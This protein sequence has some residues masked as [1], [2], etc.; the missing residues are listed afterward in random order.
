M[1]SV[2]TARERRAV[3]L[4]YIILR[5]A[6]AL[7][8]QLQWAIPGPQVV[9]RTTGNGSHAFSFLTMPTM[10]ARF[11]KTKQYAYETT[12]IVSAIGDCVAVADTAGRI[13]L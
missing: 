12:I 4:L 8:V 10:W 2:A 9:G 13:Y 6:S 5:E 3:A 1:H 11:G 7:S